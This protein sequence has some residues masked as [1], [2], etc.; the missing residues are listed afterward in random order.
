MKYSTQNHSLY[1]EKNISNYGITKDHPCS[2]LILGAEKY[3]IL[4]RY[5]VKSNRF[6]NSIDPAAT[7]TNA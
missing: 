3:F 6:F 5:N 4:T 2:D 7:L 1:I